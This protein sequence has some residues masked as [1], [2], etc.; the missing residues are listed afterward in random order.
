M[1]KI[2]HDLLIIGA[3]PS[4]LTAALYSARENIETIMFEKSIVGGLA[5]MTD[6][7]E[8]YPGFPEG[9]TGSEISKSMQKQAERFGAKIEFGEVMTISDNNSFKTLILDGKAVKARAVLIATGS[10]YRKLGIPGESENYGRGVH[11]C[12]TCDGAFYKGKKVVVV[13]GGNSAIQEAIFLTKFVKHI[14]IITL[15]NITA[16][17]SL[18]NKLEQYVLEGMVTVHTNTST[19]EII[20]KEN[21]VVAVKVTKEKKQLYID[22]DGVFVF[23]GLVPNT[24]F[25]INSGISLDK[26][27]F[28]ITDHNM[29]TNISGIFASGDVRSGATMQI[30]SA[31]GEG[32]TAA[33]SISEYL[34]RKEI[35]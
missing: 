26:H 16:S 22:T 25:L 6:V 5:A 30:A 18:K 3:G 24:Q 14:D 33:I 28:V 32:A 2:I 15:A 10:S 19:S 11:Y 27:G 21:K 4:A 31:V 13:G 7:I 34:T 8:N 20:A 9:I 1:T 12:A 29:E 35:S 17:E 23:I